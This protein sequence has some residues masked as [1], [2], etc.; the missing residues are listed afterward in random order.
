M[1]VLQNEEIL[2]V[3]K[4]R[5]PVGHACTNP[6]PPTH[7]LLLLRFLP[8]GCIQDFRKGGRWK[9]IIFIEYFHGVCRASVA[10]FLAI[11]FIEY[12][13]MEYAEQVLPIF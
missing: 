12:I 4:N 5:T 13:F 10:Y 2:I 6:R 8:F 1:Q 11:I 7:L 3:T 9:L